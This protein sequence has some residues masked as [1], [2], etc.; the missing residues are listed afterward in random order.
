MMY[1]WA[2][3]AEPLQPLAWIS[4]MITAAAVMQAER[5]SR[6]LLGDQSGEE[7]SLGQRP[8]EGRRIFALAM[9]RAN[10]RRGNRRTGRDRAA[11]SRRAPRSHGRPGVVG[12]LPSVEYV[13]GLALNHRRAFHLAVDEGV[14]DHVQRVDLLTP[15]ALQRRTFSRIPSAVRS[16][17]W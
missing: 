6:H 8:D 13:A 7:S 17:T 3:Q 9:T 10:I 5:R 14:A 1:I 15:H 11:E 16:S 2:W 4:S 12:P